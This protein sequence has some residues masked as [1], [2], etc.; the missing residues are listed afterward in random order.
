MSGARLRV[1]V[2]PRGGADRID[3]IQTDQTGRTVVRVRVRAVPADG[4]AN[5]AVLSVLSKALKIPR[6]RLELVAGA[7]ARDKTI[8]VSGLDEVEILDRLLA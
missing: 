2:T 6:S 8:W 5:A 7:G 4:E 3:G 1:R